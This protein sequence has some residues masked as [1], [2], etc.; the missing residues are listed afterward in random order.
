MAEEHEIPERVLRFIGENIDDVPQ[1]ETL[2]IMSETPER[3]WRVAEIAARNYISEQ[4]AESVLGT[5]ARRGLVSADEAHLHFRFAPGLP[6]TRSLV[7]EVSVVYQAN[8]ARIA[9]FIHSKP[10]ASIKEFA[11]AFDFKKD[12]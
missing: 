1:L 11:R 7:A 5:L 3:H 4:R 2:L 12:R 9:T 6:E 8:L 10:S